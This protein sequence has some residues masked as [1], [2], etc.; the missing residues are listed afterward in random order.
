METKATAVCGSTKRAAPDQLR[1]HPKAKRPNGT[2]AADVMR[3]QLE[4]SL[5][6]ILPSSVSRL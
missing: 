1:G 3:D 6:E 4:K 5:N 2:V